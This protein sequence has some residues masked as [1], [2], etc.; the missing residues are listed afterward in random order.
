MVVRLSALR[1][2][3]LYPQEIH[4]VLFSVKGWVDPRAIVQLEELCH[5]KIPMTPSGIEPVTGRFVAQCLNHYATVRPHKTL[6]N[7]WYEN[8]QW[9][10]IYEEIWHKSQTTDPEYKFHV[11]LMSVTNSSCFEGPHEAD[12]AATLMV[13]CANGSRSCSTTGGAVASTSPEE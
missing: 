12:S 7:M 13:Y 8:K 9:Y 2:G 5:W 11:P 4:L 1:T 10:K 3:R 6:V